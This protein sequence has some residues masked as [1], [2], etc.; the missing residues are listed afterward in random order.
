MWVQLIADAVV[1]TAAS[2]ADS[3]ANFKII[4]IIKMCINMGRLPIPFTKKSYT[5]YAI[6]M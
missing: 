1:A 2:F 6:W 3:N 4:Y 5:Y